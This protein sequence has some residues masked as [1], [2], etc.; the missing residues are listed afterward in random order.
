MTVE[1]FFFIVFC[2]LTVVIG[3]GCGV[4]LTNALSTRRVQAVVQAHIT[5]L[6]AENRQL[7]QA[8]QEAMSKGTYR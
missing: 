7:R 4:N 6:E 3:I 8:L 1:A 2:C 5:D